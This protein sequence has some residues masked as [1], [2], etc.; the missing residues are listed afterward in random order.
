MV[1]VEMKKY[2]TKTAT[3]VLILV[4]SAILAV[5]MRIVKWRI[6]RYFAPASDHLKMSAYEVSNRFF[7][8]Y[9]RIRYT[10]SISNSLLISNITI[11]YV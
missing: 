4:L 5:V 1:I 10:E 2:V 3:V 11:I 8:N 6:I 9:I 7:Y